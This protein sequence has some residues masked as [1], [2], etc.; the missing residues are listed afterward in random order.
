MGEGAGGPRSGRGREGGRGRCA[1]RGAR[2]RRGGEGGKDGGG[3]EGEGRVGREAAESLH[4]P[5]AAAAAD[6]AAILI[7]RSGCARLFPSGRRSRREATSALIPPPPALSSPPALPPFP[8]HTRRTPHT[9]PRLARRPPFPLPSGLP[10]LGPPPPRARPPRPARISVSGRKGNA[11]PAR[12]RG[13]SGYD[14]WRSCSD[15]ET[16]L[17]A[18]SK[19]Q[20]IEDDSRKKRSG[21][22]VALF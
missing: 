14:T 19:S 9:P 16:S 21:Y 15:P 17:W 18:R 22:L 20:S 8:P 2:R 10:A 4:R 5:D 12:P 6:A 7:E 11:K 3:E 1:G 13:E